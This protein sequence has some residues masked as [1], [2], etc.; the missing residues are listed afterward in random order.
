VALEALEKV[1][2]SRNFTPTSQLQKKLAFSPA[3]QAFP[4]STLEDKP[5]T[6]GVA[7]LCLKKSL[8]ISQRGLQ[9]KLVV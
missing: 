4:L 3:Q 6:V 2:F 5:S 7:L 8:K 9:A 1:T